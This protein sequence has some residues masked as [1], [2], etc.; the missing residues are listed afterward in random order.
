MPKKVALLIGVSEYGD[1]I[2]PLSASPNDVE[3]MGRILAD[4]NLGGF[5]EVKPL[6][7]PDP[8]T[9]Q[10]E[11][12]WLFD[13]REKE[14]LL[15]LFFSGHGITD[16]NNHL[17][18]TTRI[19][20]KDNFDATAVPASFVQKQSLNS[21]AKRQ[22]MI[23]DCCYSGAFA[24]G[25]QAKSVGV[26]IKRE[27][28]AQGRV[29]LTS[30]TATQTSFQQEGST[31]SLYTQYLVEGIE[32]GAADRDGDGKIHVQ[33][34]HNYAKGKVQDVKPN[35]KPEII[36]DKE[37]FNILL[38]QAQK[39]PEAEYRKIVERYASHGEISSTARLILRKKQQELGIADDKAAEIES[40]VLSPFHQRL[41]NLEIY[42][43]AFKEAI[44]YRYP[45]AQKA[46]DELKDLQE[47]Y[48]LRDEDVALMKKEITAEKEAEYQKQQEPTKQQQVNEFE[49]QPQ[50]QQPTPITSSKSPDDTNDLSSESTAPFKSHEHPFYYAGAELKAMG[51]EKA[52]EYC[53]SM[54][55]TLVAQGAV[56]SGAKHVWAHLDAGQCVY[57]KYIFGF[58]I[59][60]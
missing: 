2:P 15:L 41:R 4:P 17:Y 54:Y 47:A 20:A 45:L 39:N 37:G 42:R 58:G 32:T 49:T 36:L 5:D 22:V 29:V 43:E 27:L 38:A 1:G 33:E 12:K 44:E 46:I 21:R 3:A 30:S 19:T 53:R 18:L 55:N 56:P 31:L 52:D 28:G 7:N 24:D 50:Q 34:L 9:M 13:K 23:L 57:N 60:F 10:I 11:I 35:M 59:S 25:W 16:D 51:Q 8:I 40:Q 6:I 26:D 48:G 14:D